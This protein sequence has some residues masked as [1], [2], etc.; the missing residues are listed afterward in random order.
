MATLWQSVSFCETVQKSDLESAV[1]WLCTEY[2]ALA[3][4]IL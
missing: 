2:P 1:D 4:T 3:Y